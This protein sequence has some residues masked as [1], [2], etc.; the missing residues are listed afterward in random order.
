MSGPGHGRREPYISRAMPR[1]EDLRLVAGR[2]RFS[3]DAAF[4][5]QVYAIFVRSP[6]AHAR[7][8]VID[9]AAAAKLPG[10]LAI[11]TAA[12]YSAAGGRSIVHMP[13]PADAHDVKL[14]AFAGPGRRTPFDAPHPPL[15]VER[16]RYV[17]E[18]IAMVVA[19]TRATAQDAAE[20]VVVDYETLP[21]VT[22]AIAALTPGAPLIH[23]AVAGNLAV[24][25][26]F[27]DRAAADA[28]F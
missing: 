18:P 21:A 13:N 7:L 2:G 26:A 3:D 8:G 9:T 19:E 5:G 20:H 1:F 6:H 14:R 25:A 17:G 27:G 15:A 12:D 22:D 16:V 24:E 11:L 23:D 4:P 10:V 28:A